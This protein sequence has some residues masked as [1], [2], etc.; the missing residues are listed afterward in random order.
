MDKRKI[1]IIPARGGS[2]GIPQK[3]IVNLNGKPLIVYTIEAAIES[4]CFDKI[5]VATDSLEI[6]NIASE[7]DI[8]IVKLPGNLT[9]DD[10]KMI[11][12]VLFVIEYYSKNKENFDTTVLLQPTSPLRNSLDIKRAVN[13]YN[14]EKIYDTLVS[15]GETETHPFKC[16]FLGENYDVKPIFGEENLSTPRQLLPKTLKQNGAI[17]INKI[18]DLLKNKSF[19]SGHI[20]PF[21]MSNIS[22][23][24]IDSEINLRFAEFCIINNHNIG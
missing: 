17:Y 7:Y 22:S 3:N 18:D 19:F 16:F 15:F 9:K 14:D 5:C 6:I 4:R 20:Y 21:I 12:A 8:D 11:D 23:I 1:A 24:D 10:S 2:K 13:I